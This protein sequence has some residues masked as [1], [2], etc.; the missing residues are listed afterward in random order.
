MSDGTEA[1][2]GS[3]ADSVKKKQK[4]KSHAFVIST[5][6]FSLFYFIFILKGNS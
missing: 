2:E 6:V 5:A 1:V 4:K 3:V